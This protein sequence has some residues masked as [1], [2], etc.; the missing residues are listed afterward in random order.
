M[1]SPMISPTTLAGDFDDDLDGDTGL[2][3]AGNGSAAAAAVSDTVRRAPRSGAGTPSAGTASPA[4]A[5]SAPGHDYAAAAADRGLTSED[6]AADALEDAGL[7]DPTRP[8]IGDSRPAPPRPPGRRP[9]SRW[10]RRRRGRR[11][12]RRRRGRGSARGDPAVPARAGAGRQRR[13]GQGPRHDRWRHGC[14]G[15]GDR[16]HRGCGCRERCRPG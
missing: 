4:P 9:R 3:I 16:R 2:D 1:I 15:D 14:R 10:G 5:A 12:R 6:L 11:G 13:R 7:A 8:R